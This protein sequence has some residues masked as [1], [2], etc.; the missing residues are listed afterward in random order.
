MSFQSTSVRPEVCEVEGEGEDLAGADG[1][2]IE[3][4]KEE[5]EAT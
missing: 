5:D 3:L 2:D 1:H 4:D